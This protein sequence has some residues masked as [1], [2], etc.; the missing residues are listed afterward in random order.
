MGT[1]SRTAWNPEADGEARPAG[2]ARKS[3]TPGR[4]GAG[5]SVRAGRGPLVSYSAASKA[6]FGSLTRVPAG[7]VAGA[8]GARTRRS[9]RATALDCAAVANGRL[10]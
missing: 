9:N 7:T 4:R 5:R 8:A 3:P 6:G 1:L 2:G 10:V